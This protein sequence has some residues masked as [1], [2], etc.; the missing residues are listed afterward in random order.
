M[1]E[2]TLDDIIAAPSN[3]D[4]LQKHLLANGYIQ[5][6]PP[7]APTPSTDR[8]TNPLSPV[9]PWS[10]VKPMTPPSEEATGRNREPMIGATSQPT[11][12]PMTPPG[13]IDAAPDLGGVSSAA[14]DMGLGPIA[15]PK[16][17]T[18]DESLQP[19]MVQPGDTLKQEQHRQLEEL[20]PQVTAAPGTS[21]FYSQKIAQEE[22]NKANPWGSALNHPGVLGKIA[23]GLALVGQTAGAIVAPGAVAAIPGTRLNRALQEQTNTEQLGAAQTRE[24]AARNTSSEIAL[25][26]LQ[27][28]ELQSKLGK[29]A[30]EQNLV[31]D[32]EGNVTGWKD[33]NGQL[34]SI[35]EEGTPQ[36]IKDIAN[37]TQNKPH[38]EKSANGDIVQ[39]SPGKD[40]QPATAN[41][42]YKGQPN[43]KTETR[44]IV[45]PDGHA[46]D[47]IFDVTPNSPTFGTMLKDLGR[48]KEDKQESPAAAI[49][50]EKAGQN[51]VIGYDKNGSQRIM[52][53]AQAKE[54][55]LQHIT[56][57]SDKDRQD[58]E[59]N[60]SV[61]NDMGKKVKNLYESSDALKQ[62]PQERTLIATALHGGQ[63]SL[64]AAG[65]LGLMSDKS[66]EY[67]QNVFSLRESA[68]ALPKQLT[69]GSRVSEIQ[70]QA[71]WNTIPGV[72]GDDKYAEK[73]LKKFDENL[74]RLWKKVP[75][76]EG[77]EPERAFPEEKRQTAAP[78]STAR[79]AAEKPFQAPKGAPDPSNIPDG[80]VLKDAQ[81][82]KIAK[83]QG[84]KWVRY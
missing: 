73:Q 4:D 76:V 47:Q 80:K 83:S 42:V 68:L 37:A 39:V 3:P 84:G 7:P 13:N 63:G 43:Q 53:Q 31:S 71:L 20:R 59:Q 27:G 66:K 35:D 12:K 33:G 8:V 48:S 52:S 10:D 29:E 54:E 67:V 69:G 14:P 60:T 11:V 55:G 58:A 41:V 56:N 50:K 18:M 49:A 75:L 51:I 22:F 79:S 6:P 45:G 34:H 70:A 38:F 25:R 28:Q 32:P 82:N 61:L 30:T 15:G 26:N 16:K 23:H 44:Q 19:G 62:G 5:P 36:G 21:D 57:A 64:V 2:L 17:P 65:A 24:N 1:A 72:A 81:G 46:H 40:G 9:T 74:G 77:N 78:A